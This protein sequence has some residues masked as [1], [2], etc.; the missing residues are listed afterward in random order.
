MIRLNKNKTFRII[1]IY[2]GGIDTNIY[3]IYLEQ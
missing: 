2:G 3:E 1:H